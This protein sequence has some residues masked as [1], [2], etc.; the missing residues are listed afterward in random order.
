M[1]AEGLCAVVR[2]S[3][4]SGR[5][6]VFLYDGEGIRRWLGRRGT[7]PTTRQRVNASDII[8]LTRRDDA[9]LLRGGTPERRRYRGTSNPK[10]EHQ[11]R[12]DMKNSTV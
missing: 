5:H 2:R 10:L 8:P 6:H 9:S 11:G 12:R 7:D 4:P 1:V 3:G